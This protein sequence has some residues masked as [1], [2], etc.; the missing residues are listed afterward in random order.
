MDDPKL[1][2]REAAEYLGLAANTLEIW[3]LKGRG[4]RFLK[5]GRPV[6]YAKSDLDE[7]V[8]QCRHRSTSS[9]PTHLHP[10]RAA[11]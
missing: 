9:Y 10:E 8:S 5:L 3:R 11:A 2:T 4:P 1:T 6:R 7:W